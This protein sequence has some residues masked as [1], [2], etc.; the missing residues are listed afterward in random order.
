MS[1]GT[2]L[3]YKKGINGHLALAYSKAISY[4]LFSF[5]EL[6]EGKYIMY[7][8]PDF[9]NSKKYLATYYVNK[10]HWSE[11][12]AIDLKGNLSNLT[13]QMVSKKSSITGCGSINGVVSPETFEFTLKSATEVPLNVFLF[14]EDGE[15]M[16]AVIPVTDGNYTFDGLPYGT[17]KLSYEYPNI[18]T[19]GTQ[20]TLSASSPKAYLIGQDLASVNS[21]NQ[22]NNV[23]V[24]KVSDDQIAIRLSQGGIYNASII[25]ITGNMLSNSLIE[26]EA[27]TPQIITLGQVPSGIYLIKL[28]N[29]TQTLVKKIMK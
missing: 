28:Q 4:G 11:A 5:N 24:Y 9:I 15:A 10:L 23:I 17:Y 22:E 12:D 21:V 14:S 27:N 16:D 19:N 1:S 20:V 18:S 2:V 26:F 29:N 13:I 8:I 25:G 6:K 3:L 7:A